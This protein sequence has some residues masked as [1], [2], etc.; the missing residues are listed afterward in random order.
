MKRLSVW[1]RMFAFLF[2]LFG[3]IAIITFTAAENKGQITDTPTITDAGGFLTGNGILIEGGTLLPVFNFLPPQ[4]ST[5]SSIDLAVRFDT[6][7]E[8]QPREDEYLDHMRF[9]V[10]NEETNSILEQ[11]GATG[12]FYAFNATAAFGEEVSGG[13]NSVDAQ[14][15]ACQFLL[16]RELFPDNDLIRTPEVFWCDYDF[17]ENPYDTTLIYAAAADSDGQTMGED[18]LLG[19]VVQV[20]MSVNTGAFSQ[21]PMVPLGG[22]GGHLSL[23]FRTTNPDDTGFSL[24][25]DIPGIG[26]V[27]MPFHGRELQWTGNNFPLRDPET[28]VNEV[29][30]EVEKTFPDADSINVPPPSLLYRVSDA[31]QP[32][33]LLEPMWEFSGIEVETDGQTVILRDLVVPALEPGENGFGPDVTIVSPDE[34]S[35]FMPGMTYTITG[36]ISGGTPPYTYTWQT[37][38]STLLASGITGAAGDVV[39]VTDNLP[40]VSHN[41]YPAAVVI[42]FEAEDDTGATRQA[43]LN[44]YPT[45]APSVYLPSILNQATAASSPG[46]ITAVSQPAIAQAA[47]TTFRFGVHAGS[48]YPPYGPGGG[49]LPGVVPDATG[50]RTGMLN[51]GWSS[52]YNWWNASAWERDWRDCSLGGGDCY[53]G[54]VD[55]QVDFAYYAG[56]SGPGGHAMPS[57]VDSSWFAGSDARYSRL[58][59]AGFASCQALRAQWT[60]AHQAPI[61]DWF[62]AFQGAH[63]LLGYNGNMRDV[64]FGPRLVDNMRMPTFLGIPMP[65]AQRSI[66]EAWVQ[67]AFQM[68]AG[69]PAYLYAKGTNG[70]NPVNNKLPRP[71][72]PAPPRP[73]PVASYHWVWWND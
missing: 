62:G 55:Y 71:G 70:V 51:Y 31:A 8:Q 35:S 72:D 46:P 6:I 42:T 58:R 7:G 10:L 16:E 13:I 28:V 25:D 68:N 5:G 24:V 52:T 59:W 12:G 1:L 60:P 29:T 36:N 11:Y 65:W 21:V 53:F 57:S 20:P 4:V 38:D 2:T 33:K 66:R 34:G 9:S 32:Q 54:G 64:A 49:D 43:M 61:R 63:M 56:H 18:E 37:S 69:S 50:F 19:I 30:N 73:Y 26:A 45:V 47:A 48:D 41:G 23:L 27:A 40:V 14:A 67:T 15:L 3:L 39:V 44:L 17:G 22:A